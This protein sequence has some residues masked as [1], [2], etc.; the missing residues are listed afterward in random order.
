MRSLSDPMINKKS[1]LQKSSVY[2]ERLQLARKVEGRMSR[3][4]NASGLD[5]NS[6]SRIN[7]ADVSRKVSGA[8]ANSK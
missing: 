6:N 1:N 2:L 5:S 8:D 4:A 7:S 3:N